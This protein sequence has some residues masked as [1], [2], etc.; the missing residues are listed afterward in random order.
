MEKCSICRKTVRDLA[1]EAP[2]QRA[3]SLESERYAPYNV[4]EDCDNFLHWAICK[5]LESVGLVKFDE[6]KSEFVKNI[7]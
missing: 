1:E 3:I 2:N 4:C 7:K 6:A 5:E